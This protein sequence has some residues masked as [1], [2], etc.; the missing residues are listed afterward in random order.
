[1]WTSDFTATAWFNTL[2]W[3]LGVPAVVLLIVLGT[4]TIAKRYSHL[5]AGASPALDPFNRPWFTEHRK[6]NNWILF[7]LYVVAM[8]FPRDL[9]TWVFIGLLVL[10]ASYLFGWAVWCIAS[11]QVRDTPSRAYCLGLVTLSAFI[12]TVAGGLYQLLRS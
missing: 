12:A 2:A 6:R 3:T 11:K 5:I 7:G 4:A 1:M 8:M 9:T 10:V